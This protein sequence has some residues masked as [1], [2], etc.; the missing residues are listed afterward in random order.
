[1]SIS[2]YPENMEDDIIPRIDYIIAFSESSE[3]LGNILMDMDLIWK[4]NHGMHIKKNKTK[5]MKSKS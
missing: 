2:F 5:V 1:M 3:D 4:E